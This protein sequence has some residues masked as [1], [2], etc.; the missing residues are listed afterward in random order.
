MN[1]DSV[2]ALVIDDNTTELEESFAAVRSCGIRIMNRH[3]TLQEIDA[4]LND[5][6]VNEQIVVCDLHLGPA[7]SGKDVLAAMIDAES[8]ARRAEKL[9]ILVSN[10]QPTSTKVRAAMGHLEGAANV[11][12]VEKDGNFAASLARIINP[13]LAT[14]VD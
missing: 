4:L 12:F 7:L 1:T 5:L 11:H 2:S 10:A 13:W 9:F 3:S 6:P 14:Y 8:P